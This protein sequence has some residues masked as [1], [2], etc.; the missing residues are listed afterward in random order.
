MAT[1]MKNDRL[2][3]FVNLR[4]ELLRE[5]DELEARLSEIKTALGEDPAT[6]S[7]VVSGGAVDVPRR[8]GPG[9]RPKSEAAAPA[10][11]R[12][13]RGPGKPRKRARNEMSLRDA[14]LAATKD[15]PLSAQQI[16]D[17][18]TKNGYNFSASNPLNSLRTLLYSNN[19][20]KNYGGKFGPA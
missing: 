16:L 4:T 8:R 19:S 5:K 18:V 10:T 15:S 3:Q 13:V 6:G 14:V 2:K 17:A 20:F 7:A 9:R 12:A 1:K 11:P